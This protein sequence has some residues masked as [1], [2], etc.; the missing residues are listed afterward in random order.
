MSGFMD[1][2][3][4]CFGVGSASLPCPQVATWGV[5]VVREANPEGVELKSPGAITKK[6]SVVT[7]VFVARV[8][9]GEFN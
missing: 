6:M 1:V 7:G 3:T 9:A 5:Y 2:T 8:S 4:D